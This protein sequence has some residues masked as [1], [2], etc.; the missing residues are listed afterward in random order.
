ML[1][2]EEKDAFGWE[3]EMYNLLEELIAKCDIRILRAGEKIGDNSMVGLAK[4]FAA[5]FGS[6]AVDAPVAHSR[7]GPYNQSQ[8]GHHGS[9]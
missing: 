6:A 7:D 5:V 9:E 3:Y 1:P 2:Q 8:A 4:T